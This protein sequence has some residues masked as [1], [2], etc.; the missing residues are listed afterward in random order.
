[1]LSARLRCVVVNLEWD[2]PSGVVWLPMGGK[3]VVKFRC[4]NTWKTFN[5]GA[6]T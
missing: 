4:G 1:M 2:Q 3:G 5:T 6:S